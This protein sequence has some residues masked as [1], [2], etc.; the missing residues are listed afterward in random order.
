MNTID[1]ILEKWIKEQ[2][3]EK[4]KIIVV[5]RFLT[6]LI[7]KAHTKTLFNSVEWLIEILKMEDE[8]VV[9]EALNVLIATIKL[10][11]QKGKITK[12]HENVD[13]LWVSY[14]LSEGYNL[15][16]PEWRTFN[17]LNQ[18]KFGRKFIF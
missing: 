3:L 7:E 17:E 11:H 16:N 13:A 1:E 10:T 4:V 8:D 6:N 18:S 15:G 2:T 14:F 5:L 12:V 9:L